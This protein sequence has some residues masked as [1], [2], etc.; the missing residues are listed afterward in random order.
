MK[1]VSNRSPKSN[2]KT[3]A[4]QEQ[5]NE[6]SAQKPS[7][8]LPSAHEDLHLMI[9]RRAYELYAERNYRHRDALDDWLDAEREVLSQI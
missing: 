9:Q 8:L 3:Q 1:S 2:R 5:T 4:T 7:A 6:A